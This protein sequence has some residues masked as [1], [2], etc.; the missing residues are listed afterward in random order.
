MSIVYGLVARQAL[1]LA[2]FSV[3]EAEHAVTAKK[4]I[5]KVDPSPFLKIDV[6]AGELDVQ[7]LHEGGYFVPVPR[8]E[9]SGKGNLS[10]VPGGDGAGISVLSRSSSRVFEVDKV[11]PVTSTQ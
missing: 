4:L 7:L 2:E 10:Q 5:G 11:P 6:H 1:V 8:T 3:T 9:Q